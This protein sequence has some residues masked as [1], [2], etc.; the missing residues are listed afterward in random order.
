MLARH[1]LPAL[2][3]LDFA[4]TS[5]P[6]LDITVLAF[7]PFVKGGSRREVTDPFHLLSIGAVILCSID[8]SISR[9]I[10][11]P[12]LSPISPANG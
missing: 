6:D 5:V 3:I 11:H 2:A 12:D 1:W 7:G 8:D 9:G 4:D 10:H